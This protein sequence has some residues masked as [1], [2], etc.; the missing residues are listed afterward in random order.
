MLKNYEKF[1]IDSGM[2]VS[3]NGR[4]SS[5]YDYVR[6][7]KKVCKWEEKSVEEL[8]DSISQILPMYCCT[9]IH[10]ARGRLQSRSIRSSLAKFNKF[11][12]QSRMN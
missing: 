12:I 4:K 1:L 11:V 3:A 7:L 8:A 10:A 9:G 6:A 2:S 5:V